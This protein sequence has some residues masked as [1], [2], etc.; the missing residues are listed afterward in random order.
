MALTYHASL[1]RVANHQIPPMDGM[2]VNVT[3]LVAALHIIVETG[4]S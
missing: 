1:E 3:P 2:P 4:M